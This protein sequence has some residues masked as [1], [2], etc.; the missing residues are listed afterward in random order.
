MATKTISIEVDAYDM[1]KK[2]KRAPGESFSQVV[3]RLVTDRPALTAEE[4]EEAMKPFLGKGAGKKR[5]HHHA[6]A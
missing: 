5:R 2:E 3:R 6:A 1:L 4:L